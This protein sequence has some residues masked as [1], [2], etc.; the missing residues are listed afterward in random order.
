MHN[1]RGIKLEQITKWRHKSLTIRLFYAASNYLHQNN[2]ALYQQ[3]FLVVYNELVK[4]SSAQL[5]FNI[6]TLFYNS[7][8]E[9]MYTYNSLIIHS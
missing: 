2:K 5:L 7:L 8:R 3:Y 1:L 9:F 6:M 4:T